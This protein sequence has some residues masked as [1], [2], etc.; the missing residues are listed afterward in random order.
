MSDN[1]AVDPK[2]K[3]KN[4]KEDASKLEFGPKFQLSKAQPLLYAEVTA[5]LEARV[6]NFDKY[7]V[8]NHLLKP[9]LEYCKRLEPQA[10]QEITKQKRAIFEDLNT[11]MHPFELVQ[12]ANLSPDTSEEAFF[13]IPTLTDRYDAEAIDR[14]IQNMSILKS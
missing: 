3:A 11:P 10:N 1:P 8:Q 4:K 9:T 12:M 14:L 7:A 2:E 13:L 5:L 6:K